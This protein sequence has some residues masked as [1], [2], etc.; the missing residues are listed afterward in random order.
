M[1]LGRF[2]QFWGVTAR[3]EAH[4][5]NSNATRWQGYLRLALWTDERGNQVRPNQLPARLVTAMLSQ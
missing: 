1:P 5:R 4:I 3:R 2:G